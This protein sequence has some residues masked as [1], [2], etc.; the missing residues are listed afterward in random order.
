MD[1]WFVEIEKL[2]QIASP[3][4]REIRFSASKI[5]KDCFQEQL[6]DR[7]SQNPYFCAAKNHPG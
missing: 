4:I 3:A 5:E 6:T 2:L 1:Q 7:Q